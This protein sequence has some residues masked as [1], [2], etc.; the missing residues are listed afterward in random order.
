MATIR[1]QGDQ[2]EIDNIATES[3]QKAI[4]EK[5]GAFAGASTNLSQNMDAAGKSASN[6]TGVMDL[7]GT[8]V[9]GSA[10]SVM[11][12]AGSVYDQTARV[13]TATDQLAKNFGS[14]GKYVGGPV[15][16]IVKTAES[17]V[18]TFRQ[19]SESGAAFGGDILEMKNS[20]AQ[21]R[22][23][24]DQ[25]AGVVTKNSSDFAALGGS[26]TRGARAF[27]FF[28]K[29]FFESTEGYADKLMM[30]GLTTEGINED[31]SRQ[32]SINRRAN[33][34]DKAQRDLLLGSTMRITTEMDALAKMTGKQKDQIKAE[35]DASMRKGQIE[36][37]FRQIELTQGKEAAMAARAQFQESI[38]LASQA[39]PGAVAA[40][41]EIFALGGVRSKEAQAGMVALGGASQDLTKTFRSIAD[42]PL[43]NSVDNLVNN[44]GGAISKR[45]NSLDFANMAILADANEYAQAA[46]TTMENFGNLAT[47]IQRFQSEGLSY[48]EAFK[49]AREEMQAEGKGTGTPGSELTRTVNSAELSI[50]QLGAT[51]NMQLLGDTGP[52]AALGGAFTELA[53]TLGPANRKK[54]DEGADELIGS[55]KKSLGF[56]ES[57]PANQNQQNAINSLATKLDAIAKGPDSIA[58]Q[59]AK[60]L[61]AVI[62]ATQTEN[63]NIGK[64]IEQAAAQAGGLD[65]FLASFD[66]EAFMRALNSSGQVNFADINSAVSDMKLALQALENNTVTPNVLKDALKN[67]QQITLNDML[68]QGQMTVNQLK[69]PNLP[70]VNPTSATVDTANNNQ[71]AVQNASFTPGSGTQITPQS[72]QSSLD[73]LNQTMLQLVNINNSQLNVNNKQLRTSKASVGNVYKGVSV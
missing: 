39:G 27:T 21:T 49:K 38:A 10:K 41:E 5:M 70:L 22:M 56:D 9:T 25:F 18:D 33:L 12:F 11:G 2:V 15:D 53:N 65:T 19:M 72:L 43:N 62:A 6:T 16:A 8:A 31:L 40:A 7:L 60:E 61:S 20:A 59:N 69:L 50:K 64:I 55:L 51:I 32:M 28:S 17:Y 13:S 37:K 45:V 29:A 71:P 73:N 42:T 36:A 54:I 48:S 52:I 35:V 44:L 63:P 46:A 26:V 4:A 58:A 1:I 23:T 47:A 30:L 34:D 3:T 66:P 67:L 14:V 57:S 24:L 68:V